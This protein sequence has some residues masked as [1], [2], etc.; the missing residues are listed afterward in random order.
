MKGR[1][2]D[3]DSREVVRWIILLSWF[4]PFFFVSSLIFIV[5]FTKTQKVSETSEID[6]DILQTW[7]LFNLILC[8]VIPFTCAD[9]KFMWSDAI[10]S[11]VY[12]LRCFLFGVCIGSECYL[13][14]VQSWKFIYFSFIIFTTQTL[15]QQLLKL[16][17]TSAQAKYL[18]RAHRN[19]ELGEKDD[20]IPE[21]KKKGFVSLIV[22]CNGNQISLPC[23]LLSLSNV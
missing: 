19:A 7:Y 4:I 2:I 13:S 3:D 6:L 20:K 16:L 15:D 23:A 9:F 17:S 8:I 11:I 12:R 18:L 10:H 1:E 5:K 21:E 22:C 14:S